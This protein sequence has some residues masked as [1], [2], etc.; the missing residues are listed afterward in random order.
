V[1]GGDDGGAPQLQVDQ[2]GR[3]DTSNNLN[4]SG[5]YSTA[6]TPHGENPLIGLN[7]TTSPGAQSSN[8]DHSLN[9]SGGSANFYEVSPHRTPTAQQ[10]SVGVGAVSSGS[11]DDH[12]MYQMASIESSIQRH[13]EKLLAAGELNGDSSEVD[14]HM[15]GNHNFSLDTG[16]QSNELGGSGGGGHYI[17]DDD[18]DP[19]EASN[20][21]GDYPVGSAANVAKSLRAAQAAESDEEEEEEDEEEE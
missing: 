16:T 5:D 18:E 19:L 12:D 8:G 4:T 14:S 20:P 3:V 2:H 13:S 7:F 15:M 6:T 11:G 10:G 1:A 21:A 17:S 9:A